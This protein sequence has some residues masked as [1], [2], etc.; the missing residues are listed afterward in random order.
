MRF[1]FIRIPFLRGIATLLTAR[2]FV[3]HGSSMEPTF[4]HGDCLLI[5]RL[6]YQRRSPA[7]GDAVVLRYPP[8]QG[9][10]YIKRIIGL[11]G[12]TV[13]L[14]REGVMVNGQAL[15]EPY[16]LEAAVPYRHDGLEWTLTADHYFVLGD[17]RSDSW[18]SRRFGPVHQDQ[19]VGPARLCYWPPSRWRFNPS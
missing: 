4:R 10:S 11:P 16:L 1:T 6:A 18:D 14:A 13:S 15:H 5:D 12:E 17:Q 8:H 19:I 2:R 7:R 3:V 9:Q